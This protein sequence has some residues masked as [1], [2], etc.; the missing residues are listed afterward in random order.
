M[1]GERVK[2]PSVTIKISHHRDLFRYF[3]EMEGWQKQ[4][5][6]E[7]EPAEIESTRSDRPA[8]IPRELVL[9]VNPPRNVEGVFNHLT[10]QSFHR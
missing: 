2:P 6:I 5:G 4:E 9:S 8:D 1:E 3:S 7:W 10:I